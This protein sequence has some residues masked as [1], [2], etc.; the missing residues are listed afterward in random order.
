MISLENC[1][2]RYL[3]KIKSRNLSLGVFNEEVKGFI[4]IR[5]KFNHE[6]LFT[7]YHWDTGAP[8]GTVKPIEI[9]NK[10]SDDI[11]LKEILDTIDLNSKRSVDFEEAKGWY[12]IDSGEFDKKIQPTSVH[13]KKLF[14]YLKS[15]EV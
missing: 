2:N 9:L 11:E 5:L 12:Y 4:G 6:F 10:I 1:K 8:F 15:M 3:Y 14:D 7:E 13:N